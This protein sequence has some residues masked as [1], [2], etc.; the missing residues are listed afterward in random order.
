MEVLL[1]CICLSF[2]ITKWFE[3]IDNT[4]FLLPKKLKYV[5][6]RRKRKNV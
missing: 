2:C 3:I 6:K 5:N 1:V 4:S